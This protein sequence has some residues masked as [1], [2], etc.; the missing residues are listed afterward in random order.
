MTTGPSYPTPAPDGADEEVEPN[1]ACAT[2]TCLR[3]GM[4]AY[5]CTGA[6][7]PPCWYKSASG[8]IGCYGYGDNGKCPFGGAYDC[9]LNQQTRRALKH[10]REP[11]Y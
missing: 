11:F 3:G 5:P 2:G 8:T 7:C 10:E 1:S 6:D 9:K 4:E